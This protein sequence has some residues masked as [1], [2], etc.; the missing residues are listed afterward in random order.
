MWRAAC[1]ASVGGIEAD[2]ANARSHSRIA[3]AASDR[4]LAAKGRP[5]TKVRIRTTVER[6]EESRGGLVGHGHLWLH[7]MLNTKAADCGAEPHCTAGV[8]TVVRQL[9]GGIR[10]EPICCVE[11]RNRSHRVFSLLPDRS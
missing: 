3:V 2:F 4:S 11:S 7:K 8:C 1:G 6:S 10:E 9:D 5:E